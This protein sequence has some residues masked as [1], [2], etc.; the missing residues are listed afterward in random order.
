MAQAHPEAVGR[1]YAPDAWQSEADAACRRCVASARRSRAVGDIAPTYGGAGRADRKAVGG[2]SGQRF[3]AAHGVAS[4]RRRF[5]LDRTVERRVWQACV[6]TCRTRGSAY[7][8][9][10]TIATM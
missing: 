7:S 10:K 6:S 3:R 9:K 5:A 8:P 4:L 2:S 1:G